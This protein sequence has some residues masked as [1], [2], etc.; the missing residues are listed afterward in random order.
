MAQGG[1]AGGEQ[2]AQDA[3]AVKGGVDAGKAFQ[4]GAAEEL[5]EDGFGLVVEGVGGEDVGGV[6]LGEEGLEGLVAEG[7]GGFFEAFL[8]EGGLLASVDAADVEGDGEAGA[9]GF[10]EGLVG[11][12]FVGSERVIDVECGE[13]DAEG[14]A[15]LGVGGVEEKQE[16]GGVG[17]AGEGEAGAV[18]GAEGSGGE[19]EHLGGP[20][21]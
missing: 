19:G 4:P 7:A 11:V 8:V 2:R 10:D 20:V 18:A 1:A 3:A 13:A 16:G 14:V 9:E 12:G 6:A 17:A 15:R 21:F 5:H